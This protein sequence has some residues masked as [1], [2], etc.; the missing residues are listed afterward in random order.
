MKDNQL[1]DFHEDHPRE[2][3]LESPSDK[4]AKMKECGCFDKISG[5]PV[6]TNTEQVLNDEFK[7]YIPDGKE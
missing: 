7:T 2:T 3:L 5:Q 1:G 6:N 4:L